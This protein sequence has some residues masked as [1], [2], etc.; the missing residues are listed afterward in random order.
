VFLPAPLPRNLE[1]SFRDLASEKPATRASAIRDVVRHSLRSDATRERAIPQLERTLKSDDVAAVRAEAAVALADVAAHEALATL[2]V[3]VEDED[4]HVRQMALSALGEIGDARAA[5]RLS[6]ALRD[7]RPEVRYQAVIAFSR[8][9]RDD[10][11]AVAAAL[12][13]ALDDEDPA[14]RYIA[15]RIAEERLASEDAPLDESHPLRDERL[16]ARAEQL[17][18]APDE[19]VAVVAGLY[20]ARLGA[21]HGRAIVLDVVAERRQTPE[22]EDEQAC[23]ELVGELDLRDAMVHLERRAWGRRRVLRVLFSWGAGDR[24]SCAWHARI[25]LA[26]MGHERARAEILEELASWRRE[27]REAAVVA[28]G[29]ARLGEARASLETLLHAPHSGESV[30]AALVR[31]ALVRLAAQ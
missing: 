29:R 19:A 21:A 7:A 30:D 8:V 14:I 28:V 18:D 15:M 31:E 11:P 6:R 1:A 22:I 26:R 10:A 12:A 16:V 20:L 13:R 24:A 25:A 23:V 17:A 5:A 4:A 3:A 9:S 2:L 27:V